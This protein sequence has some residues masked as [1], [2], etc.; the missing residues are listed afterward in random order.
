MRNLILTMGFSLVLLLLAGLRAADAETVASGGLALTVDEAGRVVRLEVG[1]KDV[2]AAAA[3]APLVE[4]ADV[5]RGPDFVPGTRTA[6]DLAS[7]LELAF[8]GIDVVASVTARGLAEGAVRFTCRLAGREDAPARG[9]VLRFGFPIN[10]VGWRW[11]DDM[12]TSRVVAE[13]QTYENVRPLREWPDLPEWADRP[14][15]RLGSANRNFCTVL[16]GPVGLGLASPI[17]K[18]CIFRTSYD[19]SQRRLYLVY[20]LALSPDT[21]KPNQW[22][23]EFDLYPCDPDWGFRGG[24]DVYYRLHPELFTNHVKRPGQWMAFSKLSQIDNANEFL[25]GVQWGAPEVAYDD[26]LGVPSVVYLTH[27]GQFA[28][29]AGYDPETQPLPGRDVLVQTMTEAFRRTTGEEGM[30]PAVALFD[31]QGHP[32][33]RKT[34]AYGHIIAQF[35]MAPSLPYGKLLL[36]R[37]AQRTDSMRA[38][39]GGELDGFGYDGL[40]TGLNYRE[41]HFRH[42]A[43]PPLW[44]PVAKKPLLNNHFDSCAFA[45]AAAES[46]RARGQIS[47]MNG[48]LHASF[49]VAPWLDVFGAETGLRIS[50]EAFNYVRSISRHKPVVTLLKGNFEQVYGRDEIELFMKRSLAYGVFP[51]FFDWFTSAL[52]PGGRYWD[53][54]RYYERDRDLFRKYMPLVQTLAVAGW[55]PI[56]HA[57]SSHE[58]VFVERFGP[59]GDG[60]VWLTLLNEDAQ[61]RATTITIDA[62]ALRLDVETIEC[63]ELIVGEAVKPRRSAGRLELDLDVEGDGVRLL[64]LSTPAQ[65][66]AWRLAQARDAVERGI[67]MREVDA[68]KPP[69]AISWHPAEGGAYLRE[70]AGEG[71]RMVFRGDGRGRQSVWQW[72]ML[73]QPEAAPVTLR[74]RAA[75]ENLAGK[76]P[77]RVRARWAWVSPG[78]SHYDN[79]DLNLPKG[80]YDYQDFE[81]TITPAHPVRAI[82]LEPEMGADLT[83]TLRITSITL[84]D[85]FRDDYVHNARFSAWYE[86]VPRAMRD[87]LTAET[88]ALN[89]ALEAA[90]QAVRADLS[91]E[92]ARD[93]LLGI[94]ARTTA[95]RQWIDREKAAGACRR[96]LRDVDTVE[97]YVGASLL[98]ALGLSSP[99]LEAPS[100]VAVG[101]AVPVRAVVSPREDIPV[102]TR[103]RVEGEA[104]DPHLEAGPGGW[105][106]L[107][108]RD[109]AQAGDRV[110]LVGEVFLGPEGRSVPVRTTRE[111]TVVQPLEV[112]LASLGTSTETGAMTLAVTV[113]NNLSRQ[114]KARISVGVP[115]GWQIPAPQETSLQPG[116]EKTLRIV[117]APGGAPRAGRT[118][119]STEVVMGEHTARAAATALW[120]PPAANLVQNPGFEKGL[121]GWGGS[122]SF[123]IDTAAACS[124]SASLRLHNAERTGRSHVSQSVTLNQKRPAP[125]LVRVASRAENVAGEPGRGYSLYVDI[126]Y[127]DGTPLYGQHKAFPA[128]TTQWQVGEL[129]IQPEKPVRNVNIYLLLRD[130]AGT[131]WFDDV[132]MME[133]SPPAGQPAT[134]TGNPGGETPAVPRK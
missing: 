126:Y 79:V 73:F 134:P 47:V 110:K 13:G 91:G 8:E 125:V 43:A 80:T 33:I 124:G 16:T 44:D 22:T 100:R 104:A 7:G 72:A 83:G 52:G 130:M 65:A 34:Q 114:E 90:R 77:L 19:A 53:H 98:A 23:F 27:A 129:V 50:R 32:D 87:R 116:E 51:G 113:R 49:F 24:L 55:E 86:P 30:F 78:F 123:S 26:K 70:P 121:T 76:G 38:Q 117:A 40:S 1:A 84:G 67:Q 46:F 62:G 66:A 69:L 58:R 64:C 35:N 107:G 54:P 5:T 92:R 119:L 94:G 61:P 131:A 128:G 17:D 99:E 112:S 63:A 57:R 10:A 39:S 127:T 28:S 102:R 36:E 120:I 106:T 9:L 41:E 42:S 71:Q 11:H 20:D 118:E 12:Q 18:P 93:L 25:F 3:P 101:D 81:L 111:L 133:D 109:S 45:R 132:A 75:G 2:T 89:G 105:S 56:T 115:P 108:I 14:S 122:G 85:R 82:H 48:A 74:V 96:V 68:D 15:L 97:D 37:A 4:L 95:L 21:L 59:G 6:G 31:A 60:I 29:I 88:Q 103:L